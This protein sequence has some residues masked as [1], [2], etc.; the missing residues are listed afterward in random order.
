MARDPLGRVYTPPHVA[1]ACVARLERLGL[2][3]HL[4]G[5]VIEPGVGGGAFIDPI[6]KRWPEV[7]TIGVDL[8]PDAP[9]LAKVRYGFVADFA[10]WTDPAPS[11]PNTLVIGNPKF[12]DPKGRDP[13]A[14]KRIVERALRL[15]PSWIALLLPI[16][17]VSLSKWQ[18]LLDRLTDHNPIEGRVWPDVRA[19][20]QYVWRPR[21]RSIPAEWRGTLIRPGKPDSQEKG[22]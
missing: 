21:L 20:A 13:D 8:D 22:P 12:D 18:P 10:T 15:H 2:D 4:G 11:H 6:V 1:A 14:A 16:E 17:Y 7:N 3:L 19:V 9:G 5:E